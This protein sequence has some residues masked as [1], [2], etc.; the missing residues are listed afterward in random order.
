MATFTPNY[1]LHQWESSDAFLRTEFNQDFS[2]LDT[3]L[4]QVARTGVDNAYNL[5]NLMLQSQYEGK[6]TGYKRSL[7][8]DGFPD[9]SAIAEKDAALVVRDPGLRL[10]RTGEAAW[11]AAKGSSYGAPY[12]G[13][14]YTQGRTAV[15]AGLLTGFQATIRNPSAEEM[16]LEVWHNGEKVRQQAMDIP[17]RSEGSFEML[18]EEPL[19]LLPG[20]RYYLGFPKGGSSALDFALT[21]GGDMA[22][23]A[24][25]TSLGAEEGHMDVTAQ[26]LPDEC[27]QVRLWARWEGGTVTPA[28]A[29][30][31]LSVQATRP[32]QTLD[33]APCTETEWRGSA[34]TGETLSLGR[35]LTAG[36][37]GCTLYDY[38]LLLL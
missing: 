5:Y 22:G 26:A 12:Y 15:R 3:A 35:T 19:L 21:S 17:E 18:L 34:P 24:R 36:V 27:T 28:L 11:T 4:G 38:G 31:A 33:G 37:T 25:I 6:Y 29:G 1:G 16:S 20:D 2:I 8:F 7:L 13:S 14:I 10:F 30:T 9:E 32:A 23:T